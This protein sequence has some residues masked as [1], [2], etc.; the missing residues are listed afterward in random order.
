MYCEKSSEACLPTGLSLGDL[1]D[2]PVT[3]R[4]ACRLVLLVRSTYYYQSRKEDDRAVRMRLKELAYARPR[5]GYERLTILL[6]REGWK[7]NHKRVYHIYREEGLMVR[8][9]RGKKRAAQWRLKPLPATRV[10]EHWSIDLMSDQLADGRRF[11]IFTAVDQFSRECVCLQMRQSLPA[12]AI[13]EALDRAIE[14]HGQPQVITLDNGT[15]FASNHFDRWVYQRGIKLNFITPGRPV[16]NGFIESFNG[17]FRD[18]CLNLHWFSSLGEAR[19]LIERWR[20]EYNNS[21]PH[22][23]L[24]NLAPTQYIAELMGVSV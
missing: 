18:E 13:T 14:N 15:E 6:R 17:R 9:K 7:V 8:I 1:E 12:Q 10:N 16:E 11:R 20:Y 5:Y 23:R 19:E 4:R 22:S 24:E 21:R 3:R 2:Y